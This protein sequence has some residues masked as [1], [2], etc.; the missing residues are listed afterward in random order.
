MSANLVIFDELGGEQQLFSF[1]F[2]DYDIRRES[3]KQYAFY[4]RNGSPA[5]TR[6]YHCSYPEAQRRFKLY[7]ITRRLLS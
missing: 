7:L 5:A 4:R 1:K 2:T 6:R 3:R